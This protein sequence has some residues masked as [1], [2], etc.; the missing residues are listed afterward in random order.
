MT[1]TF[2]QF[3]KSSKIEFVLTGSYRSNKV[4]SRPTTINSAS[5][6]GHSQHEAR[7]NNPPTPTTPVAAPPRTSIAVVPTMPTTNTNNA[8]S[9]KNLRQSNV[10]KEV[11]YVPVGGYL[12]RVI[13]KFLGHK[14]L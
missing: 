1:F 5:I 11:R 2:T 12:R 9:R 8:A 14:I 4:S 13:F 6:N 7:D 10:V 3:G